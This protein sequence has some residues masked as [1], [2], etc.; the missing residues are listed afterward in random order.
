MGYQIWYPWKLLSL[1]KFFLGLQVSWETFPCSFL[2]HLTFLV[3]LGVNICLLLLLNCMSRY[4]GNCGSI[5]V[6]VL[7]NFMHTCWEL[8]TETLVRQIHSVEACKSYLGPVV[9]IH[10]VLS[11][12]KLFSEKFLPRIVFRDRQSQLGTNFKALLGIHRP[13]Q[14]EGVRGCASLKNWRTKLQKKTLGWNRLM[15][16]QEQSQK[17]QINILSDLLLI[18]C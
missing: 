4:L 10:T 11:E 14:L 1:S 9:T 15:S 18:H 2:F 13:W 12:S 8:N 16:L 3:I 5:Y 17:L 7:G 6:L